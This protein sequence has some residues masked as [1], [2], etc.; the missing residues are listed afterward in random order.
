MYE[1]VEN[2]MGIPVI[3]R[4]NGDGSVS[5]I[6]DDPNNMDYV[7][8]LAWVQEGNEAPLTKNPDAAKINDLTEGE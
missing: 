2:M 4:D 7:A 1:L 6:P 3:K 5:W 8:Y